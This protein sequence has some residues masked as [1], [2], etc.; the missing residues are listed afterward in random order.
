MFIN[1]E[2]GAE[3]SLNQKPFYYERAEWEQ[4]PVFN[5]NTSMGLG[6]LFAQNGNFYK[7]TTLK[8]FTTIKTKVVSLCPELIITNDFKQ[9]YPG[10]TVKVF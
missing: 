3:N 8:F 6:Y 9:L 5:G 10:F 7:G 1:F 2:I 4:W